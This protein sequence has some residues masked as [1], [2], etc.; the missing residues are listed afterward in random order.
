MYYDENHEKLDLQ[1][2][3]CHLDVG[4]YNPN[5]VHGQMVGIPGMNVSAVVDSS[6][7]YKEPATVT[8]FED[9]TEQIPGTAI[10]FNMKAIPGGTFMMG[11]TPKEPF[12]KPDEAPSMRWR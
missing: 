7:F 5:Y 10:S 2:I 11:S 3:S 1:C 4:H 8:A 9:Y 6:L 12:H